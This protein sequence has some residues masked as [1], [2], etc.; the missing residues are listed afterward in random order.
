MNKTGWIIFSAVV[1]LIFGGLVMLNK[2]NQANLPQ[3]N[4]SN[5]VYGKTD[6]KVTLTEF[7]DFQCEA[8]YAYYP[9]VKEVKEKYKDRVKFQVRHFPISTSH[10]FARMAASYA[11]G[12]AKQG[13]FWEMHDKIL[14]GQKQWEVATD[15]TS[16]FNGYAEDIGLDMAKLETDRTSDEV[17]AII[18]ADL[19]AVQELGGNGTPTFVLNG[20]RIEKVDNT[21]EALSRLLDD[22]LAESGTANEKN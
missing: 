9:T 5:N 4:G 3:S 8:C 14:E 22:A 12:A 19:K 6:S 13:K 20:K 1:V 15:P 17:K 2:A 16:I 18:A 10:K 21:V 7:V 11:E